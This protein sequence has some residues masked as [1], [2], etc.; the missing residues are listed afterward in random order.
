MFFLVVVD[1]TLPELYSNDICSGG[2]MDFFSSNE[3]VM[4]LIWLAVGVGFILAEL[5]APGFIVLFFGIGALIAGATAFFGSSLQVQLIVFGVS[6][7][8][9][10]LLLRRFVAPVFRGTSAVEGDDDMDQTLG[11]QA[12]VVEAIEPPHS[13]RIKFQGSFW[14]AE[15]KNL[16]EVGS[17]VRIVSRRPDDKNTFIVEKES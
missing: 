2:F 14:T 1:R 12:E 7:L 8:A 4:W 6:S 16:I 13:G 3:N 9:M 11:A 15:A 5:M 10:L 17:V